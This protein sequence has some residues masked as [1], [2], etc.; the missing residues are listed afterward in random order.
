MAPFATSLLALAGFIVAFACLNIVGVARRSIARAHGGVAE[1]LD[2]HLLE[3]EKEAAV[4]AAGLALLGSTVQL[5]WRIAAC[6]GAAVLPL[7]IVD[8]AGLASLDDVLSLMLRLDYILGTTLVL[9][10]I[11]WAYARSRGKDAPRSAYSRSDQLTHRLAFAGPA[12]QLTAADLEDRLFRR[13]IAS[14]QD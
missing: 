7:Y 1:M 10:V 9:G 12:V 4:Q 11:A 13:R 3:E 8:A 2:S 6:L 14:V 5:A